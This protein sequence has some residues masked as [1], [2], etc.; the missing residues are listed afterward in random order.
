MQ[1]RPRIRM[2]PPHQAQVGPGGVLMGGP[3]LTELALPRKL[4]ALLS[5]AILGQPLKHRN[6]SHLPFA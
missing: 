4:L 1:I 6:S 5:K 2:G 3:G